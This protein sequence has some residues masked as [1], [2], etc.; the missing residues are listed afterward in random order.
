MKEI[1]ELAK[2]YMETIEKAMALEK[3]W[4]ETSK[5]SVCFLHIKMNLNEV[6][7]MIS[8]AENLYKQPYFWNLL[9]LLPHLEMN[10]FYTEEE[11]AAL[12]QFLRVIQ[13]TLTSL[14]DVAMMP[15]GQSSY[16][17]LET[18]LNLMTAL[19][20]DKSLEGFQYN[21]SLGDVLWNPHSVGAEL[22]SRFGFDDLH[23]KRLLSYTAQLTKV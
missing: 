1:E 2:G 5:F 7:E 3:L 22:Q 13:N 23:V 21:L 17:V 9:H 4:E 11:L 8:T 12:G 18:A 19:V 20:Q 16:E 6:E 15:L 14:K 10:S